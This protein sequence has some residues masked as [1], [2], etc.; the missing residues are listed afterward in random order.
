M[1]ALVRFLEMCGTKKS[2]FFLVANKH[3]EEVS[4]PYPSVCA[5]PAKEA[6]QKHVMVFCGILFRRATRHQLV[7]IF[8]G[9]RLSIAAMAI[10]ILAP[11]TH[12]IRL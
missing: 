7:L 8:T 12:L 11:T 3:R 4:R 2:D 5:G 9:T 6:D 10:P 1:P